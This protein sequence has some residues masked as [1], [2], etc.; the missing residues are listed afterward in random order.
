LE[1]EAVKLLISLNKTKHETEFV[2][3]PQILELKRSYLM[4]H[5]LS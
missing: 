3:T 2:L 1:W 5:Q 4:L